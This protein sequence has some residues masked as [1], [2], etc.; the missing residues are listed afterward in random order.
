LSQNKNRT[1]QIESKLQFEKEREKETGR[2]CNNSNGGNGKKIAKIRLK[3]QRQE[4]DKVPE[5]RGKNQGI[6]SEL[7]ER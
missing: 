4:L 7:E 3:W 1:Q 2:Y 5:K 6:H